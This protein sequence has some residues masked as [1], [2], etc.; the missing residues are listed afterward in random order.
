MY[1]TACAIHERI[2]IVDLFFHKLH[3]YHT[4]VGAKLRQLNAL[5][6]N[7]GH[8]CINTHL[9]FL[10]FCLDIFIVY[11]CDAFELLH[12]KLDLSNCLQRTA[13]VLTNLLLNISRFSHLYYSSFTLLLPFVNFSFQGLFLFVIC[14]FFRK[15]IKLIIDLIYLVINFVLFGLE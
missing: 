15:L 8:L 1:L 13:E 3:S 2:D 7:I 12:E 14:L 9:D 4:I 5:I 6:N 11:Y 10:D